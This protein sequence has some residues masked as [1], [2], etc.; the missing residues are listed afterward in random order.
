MLKKL[1]RNE[2]GF[3]MIEMMVVII[4]IAVLIGVGIKFYLG[5]I[6][7][8]RIAKAKGQLSTMQAAMD[9][10]YVEKG[11]YPAPGTTNGTDYDDLTAADCKLDE[12]GIRGTSSDGKNVLDP[13]GK[14]YKFKRDDVAPGTNNTY[15]ITTGY[16]DV[17]GTG[18]ALIGTGT[19]GKS[20][21]PDFE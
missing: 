12:A 11:E 6:E 18:K 4:I 21:S 3:T 20:E 13:W 7:N 1:W 19:D 17:Q 14:K 9:G 5:Y 10:W 15:T 2:K 8:S 16:A